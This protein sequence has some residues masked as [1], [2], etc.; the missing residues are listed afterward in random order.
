M[1]GIF[2]APSIFNTH[3]TSRVLRSIVYVTLF[4]MNVLREIEPVI[5]NFDRLVIALKVEYWIKIFQIKK[6]WG[7]ASRVF[8]RMYA[9]RYSSQNKS[10]FDS[11][12]T[13][14]LV[15]KSNGI[16]ISNDCCVFFLSKLSK[17]LSLSIYY[18]QKILNYFWSD[19]FTQANIQTEAYEFIEGQ[20]EWKII[21]FFLYNLR[22]RDG[23]IALNR[24]Y[25]FQIGSAENRRNSLVVSLPLSISPC[26]SFIGKRHQ[27]NNISC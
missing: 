23:K 15:W 1:P 26:V 20:F 12:I 6:M 27:C 18:I 22:K 5:L 21:C 9:L 11:I 19:T 17:L 3:F 8:S 4:K 16:L 24:I 13:Q 25:W 14:Y 7:I 2:P 10:H